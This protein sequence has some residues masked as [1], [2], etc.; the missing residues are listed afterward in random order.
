MLHR[1]FIPR[2]SDI[3]Y[4]KYSSCNL[5][6]VINHLSFAGEKRSNAEG[7]TQQFVQIYYFT[8]TI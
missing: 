3:S 6:N 7:G 4:R 2:T 5:V 8:V 1:S